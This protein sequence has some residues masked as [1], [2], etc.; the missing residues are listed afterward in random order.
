MKKLVVATIITAAVFLALAALPSWASEKPKEPPSAA[1]A[2]KVTVQQAINLQTALRNLDGHLVITKQNGQEGT[3]M[4]PWEFS[5][6]RVRKRIADDLSIVDAAVKVAETARQ[7]IFKEVVAT[8]KVAP[9]PKSGVQELKAGTPEHVEY[10][11][12]VEEL[13]SA[14][15]AGTQDLA[16]IKVSELKLDKNEIGGT[17]IE[18]LGPILVDDEK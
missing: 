10:D 5:N 15:A 16:K 9:D 8:F 3:V 12:Q 11:K 18:A 7:A 1:D 14:P 4:V 6:G 17:V 13:M 2:G